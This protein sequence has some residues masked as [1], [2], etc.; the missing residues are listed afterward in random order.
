M[1]TLS[2]GGEVFGTCHGSIAEYACGRVRDVVCR[3]GRNGRR[4]RC[5]GGAAQ[6]RT[7]TKRCSFDVEWPPPPC[8]SNTQRRELQYER[9]AGSCDGCSFQR[10]WHY[11]RG[12]LLSSSVGVISSAVQFSVG[13]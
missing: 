7:L 13:P 5:H 4:A 3:W 8:V 1:Y 6:I 9:C 12:L 11:R 10:M 2:A